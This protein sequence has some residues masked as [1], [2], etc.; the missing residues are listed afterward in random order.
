MTHKLTI[1]EIK[2]LFCGQF[3]DI[4]FSKENGVEETT[5]VFV[6]GNNL[7]AR[8]AALKPDQIFTIGETGFGTGLNLLVAAALFLRT[9]PASSHLYFYSV[10]KF[11][12][13]GTDIEKYLKPWRHLFPELFD[14]FLVD[15]GQ[16]IYDY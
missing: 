11:P 15:F 12:L 3:D 7:E 1:N 5:H 2:P 4:Y 13:A 14:H 6:N 8:F 16:Y 9:A 10:E